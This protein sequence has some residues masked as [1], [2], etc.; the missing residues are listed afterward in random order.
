[1]SFECDDAQERVLAALQRRSAAG[2]IDRRGFLQ[3]ATAIGIETTFAIALADQ[4]VAAPAVQ[5]QDRGS[6]AAAYDYCHRC[7]FCR[8]HDCGASF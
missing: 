7:W 1:M 4:V 8:L 2:Q 6:I 5:G 3:L